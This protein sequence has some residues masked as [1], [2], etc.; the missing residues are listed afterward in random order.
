[1]CG[2]LG[3][4]STSLGGMLRVGRIFLGWSGQKT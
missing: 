4:G 2:K 1:M 3:L